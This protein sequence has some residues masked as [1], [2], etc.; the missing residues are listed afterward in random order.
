MSRADNE[1]Y[2]HNQVID[3][4]SDAITMNIDQ[5]VYDGMSNDQED[6]LDDQYLRELHQRQDRREIKMF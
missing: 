6:V 2:R 3:T 5:Q 4:D 1:Y